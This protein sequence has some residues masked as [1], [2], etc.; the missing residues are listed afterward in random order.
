[1]K[2]SILVVA[3]LATWFGFSQENN[4][5]AVNEKVKVDYYFGF[6]GQ[7]H[8]DYKLNSKLK[9]ANVAELK[10]FSPE[11]LI[12]LNIFG[13]KFSGDGEFG[14]L[15]S[16]ND[17]DN[18]ENKTVG[19]TS[20]I[21]VHYNLINKEKVA[22]TTGLNVSTTATEVDIFSRNNTI[23]FN[24]LNPE[25]NGGHINVRNQVFYAGPSVSL[26][27]F[28]HKKSQVRVNVGYEFAFTNGKWKS[29][30]AGIQNT[31][32]ENGNNRFVFGV[33]LL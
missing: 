21:R 33:T 23:D 2:K 10:T 30:F 14:F 9:L 1:M 7:V 32:K 13:N 8:D 3:L 6:G 27:L 26:Y 28:K 17:K 25:N 29:D 12:G 15:Y 19:F 22:L 5:E 24:D 11:F 4:D 18:T 20:R 16:K 31:V